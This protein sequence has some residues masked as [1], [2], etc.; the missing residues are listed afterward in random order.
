[1]AFSCC[2]KSI[3]MMSA[4]S[5]SMAICSA[6]ATCSRTYFSVVAASCPGAVLRRLI[7][8]DCT[9]SFRFH[10]TASCSREPA[11]ICVSSLM[12]ALSRCKS[13]AA[14]DVSESAN[15]FTLFLAACSLAIS[16][17]SWR[18]FSH[19]SRFLPYILSY[20]F[21][22]ERISAWLCEL[23]EYA[24]MYSWRQV[25][26]PPESEMITTGHPCITA[27][28]TVVNVPGP[29]LTTTVTRGTRRRSQ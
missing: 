2:T 10:W 4:C 22:H 20:R 11:R 25:A 1:M 29:P 18:I 5:R 16:P 26:M 6:W 27:V 24:D 7:M 13:S 9:I 15:D 21:S 23:D 19:A 14:V 12:T 8:T 17:I 28:C 3:L